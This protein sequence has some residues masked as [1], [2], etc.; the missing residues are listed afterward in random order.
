MI[1]KHILVITINWLYYMKYSPNSKH[2]LKNNILLP[3]LY[4]DKYGPMS[5]EHIYPKCYLNKD[6]FYDFHNTFRASK[7]INNIR[8]N[9]MYSDIKNITWEYVNNDNYISHKYKLFNPRDIDKGII[10][11]AILYMNYK[12]DYK[13]LVN[14]QILFNWCLKHEPT[15]KEQLHNLNGFKLQGNYNPFI[16]KFYD[17]DYICFLKYILEL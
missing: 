17:K 16:S 1:F 8:S 7:C 11:R 10:A 13:L 6:H 15:I 9:Y 3:T 14:K 5:I 4:N 12:Y 2:L